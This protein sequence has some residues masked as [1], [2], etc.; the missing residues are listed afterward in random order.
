MSWLRE[1]FSAQR[2]CKRFFSCVCF[3][4]I[5]KNCWC[6][7]W[8]TAHGTT[9]WFLSSVNSYMPLKIPRFSKWFVTKRTTEDLFS[10][11]ISWLICTNVFFPFLWSFWATWLLN[12]NFPDWQPEVTNKIKWIKALHQ[13]VIWSQSNLDQLRL[14]VM[15]PAPAPGSWKKMSTQI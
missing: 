12:C 14:R 7:I 9:V 8:F 1:C 15:W 5:F 4:M 13:S 2:T 6:W 11:F 10:C 3:E